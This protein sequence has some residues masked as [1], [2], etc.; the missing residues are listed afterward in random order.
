LW[1]MKIIPL[2]EGSFTVDQSKRFVPFNLEAD[3]LQSRSKGSILVEIQPFVVI[4]EEDT[5]L[6]DTGL[7]YRLP[8]GTLQIHQNLIS[9]GINPMEVTKVMMSHLHKDHAGG[10]ASKDP[11]SGEYHLN[12]PSAT[13]YVQGRELDYAFEKGLYSYIPEELAPL[14]GTDKV[15]ILQ[16]DEGL[17]GPNIQYQVTGGHTPFHQVFWIRIGR[18]TVFFGGDDAPQLGQMKN[19]FIAKYDY[20][21]KRCMELRKQWWEEA[22]NEHWTML[23]YHDVKSPII[24][25]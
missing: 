24:S 23:F 22:G 2:I 5:I 4:T 9:A 12:F 17:I 3:D 10:I 15:V 8:D 14:Q 1:A 19:R 16:N 18:E 21:G 25:R 7:G 6:F 11:H 20:N 13:Y